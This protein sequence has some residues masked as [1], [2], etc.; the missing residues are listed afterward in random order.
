MPCLSGIMT[1][2]PVQFKGFKRRNNMAD[3]IRIFTRL[4]YVL[5]KTAGL[6]QNKYSMTQ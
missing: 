3:I 5:I 1:N 6:W 2:N 4:L